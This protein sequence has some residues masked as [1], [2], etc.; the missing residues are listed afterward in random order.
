MNLNIID[1]FFSPEDFQ[2]M[3]AEALLNP[4]KSVW[5]PLNKFFI[6]RANAYPCLETNEF[7]ENDLVKKIFI[8]TLKQK[9]NLKI[10]NVIS[11]F[12]KIHSKELN[13]IFKYGMP[14]HQ[15]SQIY[16]F[17]GIVYY[18]TFGLDDGTG[19]FSTYDKD[20][21]QIEPDIIIGAKPNRCVFYESQIW[22][23]P[24]Q[25]CNTEMRIVQPFFITLE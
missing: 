7:Q 1:N 15:D 2:Y 20:S 25:D 11:F 4:Y 24:L 6:S 10:K 18:N 13:K 16:N 22:H 17:A 19:L 8:T 21:F 9:T 5:Q 23:R 12:R 3:L 14:P